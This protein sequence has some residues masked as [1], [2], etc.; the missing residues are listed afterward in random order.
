MMTDDESIKPIEPMDG[1]PF[2]DFMQR[3]FDA[4]EGETAFRS[5]PRRAYDGQPWTDSGERGK[6]L[7]QGLTIRDIRDCLIR[8]YFQSAD[9]DDPAGKT[10]E[11]LRAYEY[12]A[13]EVYKLDFNKMDP[14]AIGQNLCCEIERAMGIF[15]NR[16]TAENNDG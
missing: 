8:A 6:T 16:P 3:A 5:D 7:V 12:T 2:G 14:G 15:P 13:N 10:E 1:E 4:C 9:P 11:Q